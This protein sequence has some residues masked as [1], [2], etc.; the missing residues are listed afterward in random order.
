LGFFHSLESVVPDIQ[1]VSKSRHGQQRWRRYAS[2]D[3]AAKD[4]SA[5]LVVAEFA[6][7]CMAFPIAF[8]RSDEGYSPVAMLGFAQGQNVFVASNGRWIGGY[9]PA[10]YRGYPFR[11][12]KTEDGQRLLCID[13]S[14]GLILDAGA[15]DGNTEEFFDP[16]GAPVDSVKQVLGFLSQVD[17]NRAATAAVCDLLEVH[18]LIEP[19]EITI[20][21]KD[22]QQSVSGLFRVNEAAVRGLKSRAVSALHKE[23][24][25]MPAYCQLLSMQT[26]PILGQLMEAHAKAKTAVQN[27]PPPAPSGEIDFSFLAD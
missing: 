11:L 15:T 3:F 1:P 2:Y 20:K 4:T 25:L 13:E 26:F 27:L 12:G 6:K 17:D 9:V 23:N 21:T 24:A 10:A 19:W 5:P 16:S 18:R 22:G 8:V 14:S 7:A